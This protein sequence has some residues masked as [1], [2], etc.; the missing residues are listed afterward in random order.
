MSTK[1]YPVSNFSKGMYM[2]WTITGQ[3]AANITV[4]ITDDSG[5]TYVTCSRNGQRNPVNPAPS[6]GYIQLKGNNVMVNVTDSAGITGAAQ[7]NSTVFTPNGPA[8]G[9][10]YSLALEDA[11]DNDFN[12]V[13]VSLA[14]W[15]ANG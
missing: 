9:Y 2:F 4:T 7:Q 1:S 8:A 11:T 6:M 5:T 14:A 15:L 10:T 12:D 13:W 3:T